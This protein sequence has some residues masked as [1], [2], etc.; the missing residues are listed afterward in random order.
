MV[1]EASKF[2]LKKSHKQPLCQVRFGPSGAF[3][4]S[5]D[6]GGLLRLWPRGTAKGR[7]DIYSKGSPLTGAWFSEDGRWLLAGHQGGTAALFVLPKGKPVARLRL[8]SGA[9]PGFQI[10]S[11]TSRPIL[12]WTILAVVPAGGP[13][14]WITLEAREFFTV[15]NRDFSVIAHHKHSGNLID[16]VAGARDE[17]LVF[18]GDDLGYIYRYRFADDRLEF[19]AVHRELVSVIDGR[20]HRSEDIRAAEVTALALSPDKQRLASCGRNGGIRIWEAGAAVGPLESAEKRTPVHER[21][22]TAARRVRSAAFLA[23]G[24]SLVFGL[25]DGC[26]ET[27]DFFADRWRTLTTLPAGVR[28]LD[29]SPDLS[30]LAV[31]DESGGIYVFPFDSV[32]PK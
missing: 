1:A 28:A 13:S 18:F 17:G 5:A 23:D 19:F 12:D 27:W 26:V 30:L 3:L 7:R 14:M 31:G 8:K 29:I 11:G 6:S 2:R 16:C 4:V 15:D 10:L 21:Q 22:S 25:E 20:N 9:G 32:F 24:R